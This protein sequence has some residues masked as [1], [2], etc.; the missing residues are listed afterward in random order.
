MAQAQEFDK[1]L[2]TLP[3]FNEAMNFYRDQQFENAIQVFQ[4]ILTADSADLTTK[5]FMENAIKY[6]KEGVPKNWTGAEEM[7]SK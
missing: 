7:A 3:A 5:F 6:Q 4:S 1:K 2:K